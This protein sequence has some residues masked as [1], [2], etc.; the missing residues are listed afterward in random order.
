MMQIKLYI[1]L[2]MKGAKLMHKKL[3]AIILLT[4]LLLTGCGSSAKDDT[5]MP[6]NKT[7]TEMT[8]DYVT[9]DVV[10]TD[11]DDALARLKDGNSR[12]LN[13]KSELINVTSERRNQL[14]DGQK[15]YAVIVSCSDSRITPTTIFD[16]GLGEIFDI[17]IAGNVVDSDALGSIEYGVEHLNSPLLVVMGH[18]KCGAV[19][20]AYEKVKN[21]T[22]IEGNLKSIV[23]K[24]EPNIKDADSLDEA[25]HEN[26]EAVQEQ[27]EE[28]EIV[29]RLI[30]EGKLKVVKAHYSLD[31]KVT[32]D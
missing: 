30:D 27:I 18:E 19:T 1:R 2:I 10:I 12:F 13:D 32:F 11:Y 9:E 22:S 16:A 7:E 3:T 26:T 14:L 25:I 31:G 17:R 8:T 23:D 20:A 5:S 28:D 21:G 29:K 24:I 4:S 6:Q 15:P